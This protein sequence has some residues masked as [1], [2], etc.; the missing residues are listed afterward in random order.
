MGVTKT[1]FIR[2]MQCPRM[3]WLD[4]HH[5]EHKTIPPE[6]QRRLDQGNEFGDRAMGLFGPFTE[7]REYYPGTTHPDK[8]RMAKKTQELID[9]GEPVICEAAFLDAAGNYCAVDILRRFGAGYEMYEVKNSPEV[10][11]R[12]ITDAAFQ[13]YLIRERI[14]L[15]LTRVSIVYNSGDPGSPYMIEDVTDRVF[16]RFPMIAEN[17]DRLGA[18][19]AQ[20]AEVKYPR[21]LQCGTPYECWYADYCYER[22][23]QEGVQLSM[24]LSM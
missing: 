1:D 23:K 21:G 12:F 6:V 18:I 14:G 11:E 7:V 4:K 20:K 22:E 10:A 5:P 15:E 3:L 19:A 8:R 2:G 16:S 13:A 17:I 24:P 9:F